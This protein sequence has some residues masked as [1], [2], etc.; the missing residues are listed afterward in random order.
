MKRY[1]ALILIYTVCSVHV[2]AQQRSNTTDAVTHIATALNHLSVLEFQEPVTLAAA[3]STDFQIE[4]QENKVF[5]RPMKTGAST[6]LFVWTASR[7]FAYELETTAE[8]KNMTFAIDSSA[9]APVAQPSASPRVDEFAD[10]MLTHAFLGAVEI[11]P[12]NPRTPKNQVSVRVEQVLRTRTTIYIHYRVENNSK[13]AYH[14]TTPEAQEL[15]AGHSNLALPSFAHKQLDPRL[16]AS[17]SDVNN[18]SLPIAH[19]ETAAEDLG[20]GEV[21]QGVIAIRQALD[22]PTVVELVFDGQ[23]KATFVL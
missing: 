6:D 1:L 19:S 9:P 22:S 8:V 17:L 2:L 18:V 15:K 5:I 3:G 12:A 20:P 10:I 13:R 4:R 23:V 21:T 11:T 14:L 16:L 7:R